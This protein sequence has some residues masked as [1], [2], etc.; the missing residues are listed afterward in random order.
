VDAL[1][2]GSIVT[3]GGADVV[4]KNGFASNVT[5]VPVS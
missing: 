4:D 1:A 2:T 5:Q 3:I